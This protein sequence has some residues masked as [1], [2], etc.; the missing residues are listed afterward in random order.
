M[1]PTNCII[2]YKGLTVDRLESPIPSNFGLT[3]FVGLRGPNLSYIEYAVLPKR[4]ILS[5]TKT[6]DYDR[7]RYRIFR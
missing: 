6:S 3:A 5:H 1:L 7:A 2:Y 4:L